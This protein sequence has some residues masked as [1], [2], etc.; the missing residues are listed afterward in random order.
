MSVR[1]VCDKQPVSPP[2]NGEIVL[3]TRTGTLC[4]CVHSVQAELEDN[5]HAGQ[6]N[7]VR[8]IYGKLAFV[9]SQKCLCVYRSQNILEAELVD[10]EAWLDALALHTRERV[11]F[12][13]ACTSCLCKEPKLGSLGGSAVE[14]LPLAQGMILGS[15]D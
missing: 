5:L 12:C 3:P 9:Q 4:T 8:H 11:S 1:F 6:Q 13:T 14:C 15:R 10:E 7:E 2:G